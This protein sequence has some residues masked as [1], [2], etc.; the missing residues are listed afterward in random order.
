MD[1]TYPTRKKEWTGDQKNIK[2][3]TF[4]STCCEVVIRLRFWRVDIS[5]FSAFPAHPCVASFI[6]PYYH[7]DP[8]VGNAYSVPFPAHPCVASFIYPYYHYDPTV[9]NCQH[10]HG[11]MD[12]TFQNSSVFPMKSG[13]NRNWWS[14][15][16]L[17]WW[18]SQNNCGGKLQFVTS[19]HWDGAGG[20]TLV[21]ITAGIGI[22]NGISCINLWWMAAVCLGLSASSMKVYTIT[23]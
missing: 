17:V 3:L 4:I 16:P 18:Q 12:G 2:D 6:Y 19:F 1:I 14:L 22:R 8:T 15:S 5:I 11:L 10:G 7:Y 21:D 20:M 9:G 13:G 23:V